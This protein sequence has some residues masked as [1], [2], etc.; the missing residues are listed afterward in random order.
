MDTAEEPE[1]EQ[2]NYNHAQDAT[3][4][5]SAVAPISVVTA[6]STEQQQDHDND[7]K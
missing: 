1:R 7:Q 2:D 3:Q 4:T 5:G 6:A